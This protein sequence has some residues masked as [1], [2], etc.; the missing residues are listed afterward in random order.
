M[1]LQT[2]SNHASTSTCQE[3]KFIL[4]PKTLLPL[5]TCKHNSRRPVSST[6]IKKPGQSLKGTGSF[7]SKKTRLIQGSYDPTPY[8]VPSS[9]TPTADYN[10]TSL[11]TA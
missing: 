9:L 7:A 4:D 3:F 11:P 1:G 5:P 8:V 10:N 6:D 2:P